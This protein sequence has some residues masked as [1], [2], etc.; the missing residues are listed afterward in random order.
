MSV[1]SPRVNQVPSATLLWD[2]LIL[3]SLHNHALLFELRDEE[4][5]VELVTSSF[6]RVLLKQI[7][8]HE[9]TGMDCVVV[10]RKFLCF[11]GQ[12]F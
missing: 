5:C 1:S 8:I 9:C 6:S 12:E 3:L 7:Y 10:N 11:K 2:I 4:G